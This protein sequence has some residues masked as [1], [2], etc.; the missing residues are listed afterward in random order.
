[1]MRM[2]FQPP[3][4]F[5][6]GMFMVIGAACF[7]QTPETT[8]PVKPTQ[9]T[10]IIQGPAGPL[11]ITS[12]GAMQLTPQTSGQSG[13]D[14]FNALVSSAASIDMDAAVTARAEFDPPTVPVGGRAV[15]RIV[16]NA[17]DESVKVPDQL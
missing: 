6:C 13:Q 5:I 16:L 10:L 4:R 7:A 3:A 8:P 12:S 11:R 2:K 1:M 9:S 15:Y 17:L 14:A